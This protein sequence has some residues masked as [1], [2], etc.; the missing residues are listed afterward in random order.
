MSV[1]IGVSWERPTSTIPNGAGERR[2]DSSLIAETKESSE[3]E[4]VV[5]VK[6]MVNKL[7]D[8]S[9]ERN[10]RAGQENYPFKYRIGRDPALVFFFS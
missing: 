7:T 1:Y 8:S 5:A 10:L 9:I 3:E 4:K 6:T 2:N